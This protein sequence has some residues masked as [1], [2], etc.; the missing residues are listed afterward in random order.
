MTIAQQS[1]QWALEFLAEHSDGDLF[2]KIIELDAIKQDANSFWADLA[3]KPLGHFAPG[4]CRRFIVPKDEISYRQATQ[5]HPQDNILLSALAYEYGQGIEARRLTSDIIFSYRF[6]P[7]TAAGLYDTQEAWNKFWNACA[8]D[9]LNYSTILYCDIADFY[10]QIYHHTVENQLAE[11]GFPN[12]AIKWIMQLLES[13]TAG[14]SRGV[15]I[16]PHAIH[17]IAEMTLIPVDNAL[18]IRNIAFRRYADDIVIFCKS[19]PE[20]RSRLSLLATT[21]DT[22]QR[23]TLQRHKTR[24]YTQGEFLSV[25]QRMVEDRPINSD[26]DQLL[27]LVRRYSGGDPYRTILFSQISDSDWRSIHELAIRGIINE[28]LDSE[29]PDFI[30]LRWFYRRLTQIG[31]PGALSVSLERISELGP[32][33]ANICT[34]IGS[35]QTLDGSQ[36]LALG[37]SLLSLLDNEDVAGNEYFR[38]SILSL[39]TRNADV[40]HVAE[41]V[42]VYASGA[43]F[44]RREVLLAA[45]INEATDWLRELK[46][47]Y[48]T[49]DPWQ[50]MA[51]IYC[52]RRFPK[53][54]RKYFINR[55]SFSRPYEEALA[56]W[57]KAG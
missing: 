7:S 40:N 18:N 1:I 48:Q 27:A 17:L 57:A 19:K 2:P 11:S 34:Y 10:N 51:F 41:L 39:F 25:C 21:L 12:Q 36:W 16:G 53:D 24:I 33:L 47:S 37:E 28:Y 42:R 45:N 54:E 49:M 3:G 44:A 26:E 56:K 32:C 30:R 52:A 31:H 20:A 23:L 15:P 13:T 43:P 5:L 8:A 6:S 14:V 35:I 50:Q 4:P 22:Q 46:E 29:E 38:L 55:Q 9:A